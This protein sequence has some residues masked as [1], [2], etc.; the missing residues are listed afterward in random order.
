MVLQPARVCL[1]TNPGDTKQH[2]DQQ[3]TCL[4][5]AASPK[6]PGAQQSRR[7]LTLATPIAMDNYPG[8][9]SI[10]ACKVKVL[11][12]F[13]RSARRAQAWNAALARLLGQK[14]PRVDSRGKLDGV[15]NS[16]PVGRAGIHEKAGAAVGNA[17]M[18]CAR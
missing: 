13:E 5:N 6:A 3:R 11:G 2:R 1:V 12:G 7:P 4:E 8:R 15:A 9:S 18:S 14:R 10:C 17:D 16:F